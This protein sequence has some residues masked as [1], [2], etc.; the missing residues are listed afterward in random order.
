MC[1]V[2]WLEKRSK[3]DCALES[4]P[5]LPKVTFT[6]TYHQSTTGTAR[7]VNRLQTI[8]LTIQPIVLT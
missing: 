6:F 8:I 4:E 3:A 7:S 1:G 5:S 2:N